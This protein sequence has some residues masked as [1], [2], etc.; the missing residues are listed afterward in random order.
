ME[1]KQND[2]IDYFRWYRIFVNESLRI[3]GTVFFNQKVG[4]VA[5]KIAVQ[6]RFVRI[7]LVSVCV[8][9][10]AILCVLGDE[11]WTVKLTAGVS[12]SS[13][14]W[15]VLG[16]HKNS[17]TKEA[18]ASDISLHRPRPAAAGAGLDWCKLLRRITLLDVSRRCLVGVVM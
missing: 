8:D 1:N 7:E 15:W 11:D 17:D 18:S 16:N 14:R 2:E 4:R 12:D 10:D 9:V 3:C 13:R 6:L 5:V